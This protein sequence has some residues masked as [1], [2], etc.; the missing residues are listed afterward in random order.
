MKDMGI[1]Q[2]SAAQ[3]V[4]LFVGKDTVYE[5]TNIR[6]VAASEAALD[7]YEYH[8]VQYTKDEYIDKLM[9]LNQTNSEEILVT[10][11][12]IDMILTEILPALMM[13]LE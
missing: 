3:A 12:T 2:G 1:V 6:K 5:H 4:P 11:D 13:P 7:L 9:Q 8:E 10:R